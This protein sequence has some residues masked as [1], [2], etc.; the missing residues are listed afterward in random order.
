MCLEL[1]LKAK[2]CPVASVKLKKGVDNM[3]TNILK[4]WKL[5]TFYYD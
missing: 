5:N 1:L 2:P 4:G 3:Y